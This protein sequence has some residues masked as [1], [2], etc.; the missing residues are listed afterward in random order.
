M[1]GG[2]AQKF[3]FATD[4]LEVFGKW[5]FETFSEHKKYQNHLI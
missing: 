4:N 2:R 1:K 5:Y 3:T